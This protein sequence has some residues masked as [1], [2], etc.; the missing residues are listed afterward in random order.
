MN[1]FHS[2]TQLIATKQLGNHYS[3]LNQI[4][5]DQLNQLGPILRVDECVAAYQW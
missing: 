3:P 4:A 5:Y 1:A 2:Y